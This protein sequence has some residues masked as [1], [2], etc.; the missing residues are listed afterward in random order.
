MRILPTS[1][2]HVTEGFQCLGHS[3]WTI[4]QYLEC[5][6]FCGQP[7]DD[8]QDTT[9]NSS[10][11]CSSIANPLILI[12]QPPDIV[13]PNP[14]YWFANPTILS[15]QPHDIGFRSL[16]YRGVG[17]YGNSKYSIMQLYTSWLRRSFGFDS[18][19]GGVQEDDISFRPAIARPSGDIIILNPTAAPFLSALSVI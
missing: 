12:R 14:R 5:R 13:S 1:K 2:L 17:D 9:N 6:C 10:S 7:H 3:K 15:R 11:C 18:A 16:Q 19:L 8:L 4:I